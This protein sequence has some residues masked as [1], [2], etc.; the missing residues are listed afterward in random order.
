M[1]AELVAPA[2]LVDVSTGELLEATPDNAHRV[3]QAA[4]DLEQR[5]REVKAAVTDWVL[6]ESQR[7]GTKTLHS[8]GGDLVLSGGPA[9]DYDPSD[10][11]QLLRDAGCPEDRVDAV[12]VP[13]ITYKVNRSV[14][15]QLV[16]A[17]ADYGAAADSARREV[18]KPYRVSAG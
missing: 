2:T 13:E 3:L 10:L 15:R 9:V 7:Q 14:L 6:A 5:I 17:N 12:V 4:R 18:V 16:A 8:A 1:S 11:A